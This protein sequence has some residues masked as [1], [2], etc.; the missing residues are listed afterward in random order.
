MNCKANW[1]GRAAAGRRPLR[2]GPVAAGPGSQ[3][4]LR[5]VLAGL[6]AQ[7]TATAGTAAEIGVAAHGATIFSDA[8]A[9][10]RAVI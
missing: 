5:E 9:Q 4:A 3:D 8:P 7:L 2:R 1:L 10:N 6:L